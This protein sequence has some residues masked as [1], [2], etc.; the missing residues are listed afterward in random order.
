MITNPSF[1]A[2]YEEYKNLVYNLALQYVQQVDDA[3]D[4]TQ[5]VFI[6]VYRQYHQHDPAK[7]SLKTWIYRISIN[8]CLDFIKAKRTKKRFGF[9]TSLFRADNQEPVEEA[10]QFHHPGIAAEDKEDLQQLFRYIN[11]LPD[12]QR[13]ALILTKIEDRPQ[14]EVA[15]IMQISTKA[16]ESLLQRAKQSLSK[17]LQAGQKETV[18]NI[19]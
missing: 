3:A 13:T 15:D 16:L 6:K 7:A 8:H 9:L 1:D 12:N 5:E 4:I 17:K 10:I 14:K 2:L 19:V 18:K 11:D